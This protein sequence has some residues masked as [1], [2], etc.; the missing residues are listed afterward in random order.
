MGEPAF[1]L[2]GNYLSAPARVVLIAMLQYIALLCLLA[3]IPGCV[4]TPVKPN[5][6]KEYYTRPQS[7]NAKN[8]ATSAFNCRGEYALCAYATCVKVSG[9]DPPVAECGCYSYPSEIVNIGAIVGTLDGDLKDEMKEECKKKFGSSTCVSPEIN[10]SPFC[11]AMNKGTMYKGA[12]P[13]Y[14]ST[15]NPVD[16]D[17]T[18]GTIPAPFKCDN[19][20]T[21]TNCF[22]AACYK[23]SPKSPFLKGIGSP[24]FNATCYCPYYTFGSLSKRTFNVWN[25]TADPC[26]PTKKKHLKKDTLIY[27]G[28]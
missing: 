20:G 6:W 15:Y 22:S 24:K 2:I 18:T 23:G 9:S 4:A 25:A 1:T 13:D 27:N 11:K 5:E 10:A 3:A 14:I 28:V 21:F 7:N 16:W 17:K 8:Y 26:G 19:G 12:K